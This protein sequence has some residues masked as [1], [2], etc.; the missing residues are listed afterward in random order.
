MKKYPYIVLLVMSFS[1]AFAKTIEPTIE[2]KMIE[3]IETSDSLTKNFHLISQ[4]IQADL[5]TGYDI[6][7]ITTFDVL[8]PPAWHFA[9]QKEK[10]LRLDRRNLMD[11]NEVIS[12]EALKLDKNEQIVKYVKFFLQMTMN[13]SEFIDK[14]LPMEI[15]RIE[16]KDKKKPDVQIKITRTTDK[17]QVLFYARDTQGDLQQW[18]L[19]LKNN[20]EILKLQERSY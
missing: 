17:I 3:M 18:N 15:S 20:G 8:P 6:Y 11:W 10:I 7:E 13:Q 4:K 12:N 1:P 2:S 5:I 14:L 16:T 9:V 19:I